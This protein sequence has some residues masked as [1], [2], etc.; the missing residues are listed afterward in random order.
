M[1]QTK[2][3]LYYITLSS[4]AGFLL[5][6][7]IFFGSSTTIIGIF[8]R[9][10][11]SIIFIISCL[12]GISLAI[13]P[14][15]YNKI[16]KS[17]N[18]KENKKQFFKTVI[19]RKG[20][21]PNC[22]KFQ[23]HILKIKHKSYCAGCLGLAIGSFIS[24]LLMIFYIS[25]VNEPISQIFQLLV[26]TGFIFIG[27]IYI[28]IIQPYR[29]VIFHIISSALLVVSFFIITVSIFELT[30]NTIYGIISIVFSFLWL[31]TRVQLSIWR[32]SRI[33]N[34]CD[35]SKRCVDSFIS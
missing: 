23:K 5:I 21:H 26:I 35:K 20:H 30:G 31:E 8:D 2:T 19:K 3:I 17:Q 11:I 27:I 9:L 33:C 16:R 10:L 15:W 18:N 24:I 4:V 22:N 13:Y 29:H 1:K 25:T 12:F 14:H 7:L 6:L 28:E 32:H 34:N